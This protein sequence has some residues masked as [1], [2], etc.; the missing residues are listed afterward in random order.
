V[1][2]VEH[3]PGSG[4]CDGHHKIDDCTDIYTPTAWVALQIRTFAGLVKV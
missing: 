3:V 4:R 2:E 1:E